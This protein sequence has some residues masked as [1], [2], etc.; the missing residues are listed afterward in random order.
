MW[1]KSENGEPV[2]PQAIEV[3]E[4]FV[5]LRKDFELV[6]AEGDMPAHYTYKEWQMTKEQ[7]EIYKNFDDVISEQDDALV[8]LA[9]LISEVL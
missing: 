9:E 8:E 5:I 3:A 1:T 2:R 4:G 7:Y 6:E